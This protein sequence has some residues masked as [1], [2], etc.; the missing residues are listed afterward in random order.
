MSG[1]EAYEQE[2]A[3]I[4]ARTHRNHLRRELQLEQ[5][6][7]AL[8]C[9][10]QA[11]A[12]RWAANCSYEATSFTYLLRE[13]EALLLVRLLIAQER[14]SEALAM[15]GTWLPQARE[16]GRLHSE[17]RMLTLAA[18]AHATGV[19]QERD[20]SQARRLLLSALEKARPEGYQRLF[21]DLGDPMRTLLRATLRDMQ[22]KSLLTYTRTLIQG[23]PAP[24][25]SPAAPNLLSPQE[26]R[27]LRLLA[28]GRSRPEIA[29]ELVVS[30]N[31]V[32][33][34]VRSIYYKLNV[35][36]RKDAYDA[37]QRLGLL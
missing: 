35:T 5:V 1:Q 25:T 36:S 15:L 27:V 13:K 28:A 33:T 10:D 8:A 18:L 31:T 29:V 6:S 9:G 4:L 3:D 34:Q 26:L 14:A 11:T 19:E 17:L 37:A 7:L 16:Q 21:L 12:L 22:D 30:I 24:T 23:F 20:L 32:K 2:A